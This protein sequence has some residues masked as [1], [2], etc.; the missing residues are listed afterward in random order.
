M[1]PN[2]R[3]AFAGLLDPTFQRPSGVTSGPAGPAGNWPPPMNPRDCARGSRWLPGLS[4]SMF[5]CAIGSRTHHDWGWADPFD[6]LPE[7]DGNAEAERHEREVP[8]SLG[9][10]TLGLQQADGAEHDG[11]PTEPEGKHKADDL[12][13]P[14]RHREHPAH[15]A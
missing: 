4:P 9:G 1:T 12:D 6:D 13:P 10:K 11:E 2:T 8:A 3:P 15:D 5:C 14:Q 7:H